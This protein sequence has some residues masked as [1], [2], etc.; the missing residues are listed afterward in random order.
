VTYPWRIEELDTS[1]AR[2]GLGLPQRITIEMSK[3]GPVVLHSFL[4][5]QAERR[6]SE[7]EKQGDGG[8]NG[9]SIPASVGR[10]PGHVLDQTREALQPLS[11]GTVEDEEFD[12]RTAR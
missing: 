3:N 1:S 7:A 2:L 9:S 11:G 4:N 10:I 5:P 6:Q 12:V 8:K